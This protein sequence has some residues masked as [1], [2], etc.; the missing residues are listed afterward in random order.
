VNQAVWKTPRTTNRPRFTVEGLP[1]ATVR[2]IDG[3]TD[4]PDD[5][6]NDVRNDPNDLKNDPRNEPDDVTSL[7]DRQQWILDE[8]AGK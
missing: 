8:L 4:D 2:D 3:I 7:S 1:L 5:L 6:R